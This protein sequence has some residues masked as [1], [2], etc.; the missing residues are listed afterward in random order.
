M[1]KARDVSRVALILLV[2]LGVM[3]GC[4][5]AQREAQPT[6][7][8][9]QEAPLL[10][11]VPQ[12]AAAPLEP[13]EAAEQK[14]PAEAPPAEPVAPAS[15]EPAAKPAG[16]M[17]QFSDSFDRAEMGGDW[18]VIAG[19]WRIENGMLSGGAP[20][21]PTES[22]IVCAKKF[23]GSQRLEF[24]AVTNDPRPCDLSGTLCVDERGYS[25]GYFFGFGS[26]WNA[27]S[28]LLVRGSQAKQWDTVITAGKLH[29]V[30]CELDA[31]TLKHIVDGKE[32]MTHTVDAPLKGEWHQ[33]VGFY[34]YSTG[35]IDNVKVY[36]KA[37]E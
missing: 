13:A 37:E 11:T 12:E 32:V 8:V 21:A 23:P 4:R 36:T 17:L 20:G 26:E 14:T 19:T 33:M 28:R 30:V 25:S 1:R 31:N 35:K 16:W 18:N 3:V 22:S 15:V 9:P 34:I 10:E 7:I 5:C 27:F 6:V 29:H 24:D 2:V